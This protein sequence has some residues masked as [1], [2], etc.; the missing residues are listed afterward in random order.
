MK[1]GAQM[2]AG[3]NGAE[4]AGARNATRLNSAAA[5]ALAQMP[6]DR[7]ARLLVLT[8]GFTTEPLDGLV[9]EADQA[10]RAAR[11]PARRRAH[12]AND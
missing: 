7:A 1:R 12:S 10:G 9:G 2:R 5:F 3:A 11:L 4:Y 6:P 8:D